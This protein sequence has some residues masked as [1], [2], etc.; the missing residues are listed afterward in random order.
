MQK[1]SRSKSPTRREFKPSELQRRSVS[2]SSSK[3][4][5]RSPSKKMRAMLSPTK[6]SPRTRIAPPASHSTGVLPSGYHFLS[7]EEIDEEV[8]SLS[9]DSLAEL[10]RLLKNNEISSLE[11]VRRVFGPSLQ[12]LTES[13]A[14]EMQNASHRPLYILHGKNGFVENN[15]G[16]HISLAE[17][18]DE[19]HYDHNVQYI[20]D[21]DKAS[22]WNK[23]KYMGYYRDYLQPVL[24]TLIYVPEESYKRRRGTSVRFTVSDDSYHKWFVTYNN[25]TTMVDTPHGPHGKAFKDVFVFCKTPKEVEKINQTA[26]ALESVVANNKPFKRGNMLSLDISRKIAEMAGLPTSK[27]FQEYELK[28]HEERMDA[29]RRKIIARARHLLGPRKSEGISDK[30]LYSLATEYEYAHRYLA[31]DDAEDDVYEKKYTNEEQFYK[32]IHFDDDGKPY[33]LHDGGRKDYINVFS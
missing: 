13:L 3:S 4:G 27:A 6:V 20:L 24:V 18:Y 14:E 29:R 17:T 21:A 8:S 16:G 11:F 32:H 1:R 25:G 22:A 31:E 30:T 10:R 23:I 15:Y 2:K 19:D 28:K 5:S 26:W 33:Y 12:P 9:D 7:R